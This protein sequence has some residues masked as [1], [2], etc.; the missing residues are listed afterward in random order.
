[1]LF[2]RLARAAWH[3]SSRTQETRWR[4]F[5]ASKGANEEYNEPG[6]RLF[7]ECYDENGVKQRQGWEPI[8]YTTYGLAFLLLVV[9][10]NNKPESALLPRGAPISRKKASVPQEEVGSDE[11]I[12]KS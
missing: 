5:F 11:V 3:R 12:Q 6:G 10:L 7:P 8:T 2:T 1:M 4:R 9:G